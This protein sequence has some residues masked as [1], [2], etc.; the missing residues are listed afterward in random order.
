[1]RRRSQLGVLI[2]LARL[3]ESRTLRALGE[4]RALMEGTRQSLE[5]IEGNL[6]ST[7]VGSVL[8]R[9]RNLDAGILAGNDQRARGLDLQAAALERT[10]AT[11]REA[12]ESA[13]EA[14]VAAKLR[15]RMLRNAAAKREAQERRRRLRSEIRRIDEAGRGTPPDEDR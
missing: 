8:L 7:R 9:T 11:A 1:M 3:N 6:D 12:E 10:L 4:A 13:R 5:I 2:R 14:V 15:L